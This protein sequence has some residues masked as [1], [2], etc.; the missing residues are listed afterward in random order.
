MGVRG[1][2]RPAPYVQENLKHWGREGHK[3]EIRGKE[4]Q[5]IQ[6]GSG[7]P[8]LKTAGCASRDKMLYW[9]FLLNIFLS[10]LFDY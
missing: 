6:Q 5:I 3:R 7:G 10:Q 2:Q 4:R 9:C 8:A 1:L